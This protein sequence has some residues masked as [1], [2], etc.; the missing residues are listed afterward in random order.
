[1]HFLLAVFLKYFWFSIILV[2]VTNAWFVQKRA[3]PLIAKNPLLQLDANRVSI[4]LILMIS[5]PSAMLG[6]IQLMA[7][8]ESPFYIFSDDLSNRYL[9]SAWIVMAGLR[10]FILYWLWFT[11]G[12]ESYI[13]VTPVR[14]KKPKILAEIEGVLIIRWMVTAV[15]VIWF[16]SVVISFL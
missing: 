4:T 13:A 8:Y 5:I 12:L 1:M 11:K 2:A 6:I 16:V 14:L 9:L 15:L 7:G 10:V 3:R